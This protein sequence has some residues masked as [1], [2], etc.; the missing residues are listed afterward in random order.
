MSRHYNYTTIVCLFQYTKKYT[1]LHVCMC[2]RRLV[3]FF[4]THL[5]THTSLINVEK[6]KEKKSHF[7]EAI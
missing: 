4:P 2:I 1:F 3:F 6:K 5:R 7:K